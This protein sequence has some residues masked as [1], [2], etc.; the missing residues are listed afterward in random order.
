MGFESLY[1]YLLSPRA[2]PGVLRD[3]H[4]MTTGDHLPL[5]VAPAEILRLRLGT[6][7]QALGDPA[8]AGR[9]AGKAGFA[10]SAALMLVFVSSK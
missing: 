6:T 7:Q 10:A 4:G 9:A 8:W 3:D 1:I 5:H 2:L